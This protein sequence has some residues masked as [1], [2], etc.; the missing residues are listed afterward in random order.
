MN[1]TP[2]LAAA[3]LVATAGLYMVLS[4]ATG[5]SARA[6]APLD[7]APR[8]A[9]LALDVWR[10][11]S[12]LVEAEGRAAIVDVRSAEAF[13]RYH[14]PRAEHVPGGS[15]AEVAAR[16]EG[17]PFVL[18]YA[19]KDDVAGAL[20]EAARRRA[21]GARIHFLAGGARAWYLALALPVPL[22]SDQAA[23]DGYAEAVERVQGALAGAEHGTKTAALESIQ[24]LARTNYQ[25]SLLKAG[26]PPKATAAK[27]KI[28]GGCG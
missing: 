17:R 2:R 8:P 1:V 3:A 26:G 23:P 6:E 16:A 7:L 11:A 22:F 10:A 5:R 19:D 25:P 20:V 9:D 13:A 14:L 21:P 12:A 28:A 27:K 18:V 15:A 24:L 4:L